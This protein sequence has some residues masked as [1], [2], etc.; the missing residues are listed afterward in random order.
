MDSVA[1]IHT[2]KPSVTQRAT[3]TT[4]GKR[5]H[6]RGQ[7]QKSTAAAHV[8]ETKRQSVDSSQASK[9][10]RRKNFAA[11]YPLSA[12]PCRVMVIWRSAAIR[13]SS[14]GCVLKSEANTEPTPP[15]NSG[16]TMQS[17]AVV[18]GIELGMRWL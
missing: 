18:C 15:P 5:V 13:S 6:V 3:V 14:G 16:L 1:A 12:Q 17:A 9:R 8:S 7:S 11:K 10:L 2:N 4:E